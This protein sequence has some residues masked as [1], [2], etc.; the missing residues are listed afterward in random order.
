[1]AGLTF[2][3]EELVDLTEY[4]QPAR[5]I[6]LL[7]RRGF[8]RAYIG[9]HGRVVLERAHYDAVCRGEA[10]AP[11]RTPKVRG[12][13]GVRREERP[14]PSTKGVPARPLVSHRGGQGQQA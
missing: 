6:A 11:D 10:A 7:H 8:W 3:P 9:R 13:A 12:R 2:T 5:Q 4:E 1:M 14:S